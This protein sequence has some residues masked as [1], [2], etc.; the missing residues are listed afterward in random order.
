MSRARYTA[1]ID[2]F[3]GAEL[4]GRPLPVKRCDDCGH[5]KPCM[6]VNLVGM[7]MQ[8]C[9]ECARELGPLETKT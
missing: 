2:V 3:V 6:K 1:P 9:V 4:Q 8:L 5:E 7:P